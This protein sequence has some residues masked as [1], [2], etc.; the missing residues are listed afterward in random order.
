GSSHIRPLPIEESATARSLRDGRAAR[1]SRS[2]SPSIR[3]G[4][5]AGGPASG[6]LLPPDSP[7]PGL[8]LDGARTP[9]G[10]R[11]RSF[12]LAITGGQRP[13][14]SGVPPFSTAPL[15]GDATPVCGHS[16][17]SATIGGRT[18]KARTFHPRRRD[19]RPV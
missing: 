11:A 17:G 3:R 6:R 7:H 15:T 1:R 10:A 4:E 5:G 12:G 8:L 9:I 18:R 13:I 2:L 14:A 19:Q 16:E